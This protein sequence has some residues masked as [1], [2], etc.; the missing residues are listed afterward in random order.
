[1]SLGSLQ[2]CS[3]VLDKG[4]IYGQKK[5]RYL[6]PISVN[7]QKCPFHCLDTMSFMFFGMHMHLFLMRR[8]E[9]L[10]RV[11]LNTCIR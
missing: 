10:E 8:H 7:Q 1:M 9:T 4:D 2:L 3:R 5:L 6:S 11:I